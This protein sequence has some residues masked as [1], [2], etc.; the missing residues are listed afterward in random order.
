[1]KF[2]IRSSM[3]LLLLLVVVS[4]P[5]AQNTAEVAIGLDENFFNTL[6]D[7]YFQNAPPMEI[8]IGQHGPQ[9]GDQDL[10]MAALRDGKTGGPSRLPAGDAGQCREVVTIL[11]ASRGVV[12]SVKFRDGKIIAPLA[13]SGNYSAPLIGCVPF[14]GIA[15]SNIELIFDEPGQRLI[16]RATV[17]N[18]SL[19][20]TGG[21]GGSLIARLVQGSID[22]K[23]NPIQ[24]LRLDT[25][26]FTFPVPNS[27]TSLSMKAR[28]IRTRVQPGLLTIFVAFDFAK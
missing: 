15:E 16:A 17:R 25:L 24:V 6:L 9:A 21:L 10:A 12:T 7:A 18:V 1:M 11:R 14:E 26:A 20:G 28:G 27:N 13:F 8:A 19:N 23:V 4:A 3:A 22:K 5:R 2:L